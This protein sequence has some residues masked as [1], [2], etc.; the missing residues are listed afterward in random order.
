[1]CA[2]TMV[3][4][5]L[6]RKRRRSVLLPSRTS[7]RSFTSSRGVIPSASGVVRVDVITRLR[8][9]CVARMA[10]GLHDGR[11][12]CGRLVRFGRYVVLERGVPPSV[13][14]PESLRVLHHDGD[15]GLL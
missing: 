5:A 7:S 10:Q 15:L 11:I 1:M 12:A 14:I 6:L 8:A 3:I 9:D 13:C 2:P 4:A